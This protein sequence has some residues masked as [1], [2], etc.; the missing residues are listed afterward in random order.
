MKKDIGIGIYT[1]NGELIGYKSDSFWTLSTEYVKPDW[2][3]NGNIRQSLVDNL[4]DI[5]TS[6]DFAAP[7]VPITGVISESN[8]RDFHSNFETRLLGYFHLPC[9]EPIFTY[10]IFEDDVQP[11]DDEDKKQLSYRVV[12][13]NS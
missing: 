11:L 6:T 3:V 4:K 8:R 2:L 7:H 1:E 13:D 5:L 9:G 12:C 10:R